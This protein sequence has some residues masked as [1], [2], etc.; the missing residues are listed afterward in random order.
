MKA[1]FPLGGSSI[2]S[3]CRTPIDGRPFWAF[4]GTPF[5]RPFCKRC[6]WLHSERQVALIAA[7]AIV[8]ESLRG[9]P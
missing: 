9:A 6:S 1:A 4:L 3:D 8:R 2:C 5:A 7:R